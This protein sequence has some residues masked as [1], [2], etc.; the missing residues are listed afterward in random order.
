MSSF[1]KCFQYLKILL[2]G[3]PGLAELHS[4]SISKANRK[5]I[6]TTLVSVTPI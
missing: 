3:V 6:F 2:I 4:E 5:E 1:G